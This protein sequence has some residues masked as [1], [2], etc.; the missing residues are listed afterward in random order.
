MPVFVVIARTFVLF[1][2]V[3]SGLEENFSENKT[4]NPDKNRNW[5]NKLRSVIR[6]PGSY[7]KTSHQPE[8]STYF[9]YGHTH[10]VFV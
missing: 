5:P 2:A 6:S 4:S 1:Y 8:F 3:K 9:F 7:F 10:G